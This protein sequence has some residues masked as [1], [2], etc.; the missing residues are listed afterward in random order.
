LLI[1][2]RKSHIRVHTRA[3]RQNICFADRPPLVRQATYDDG[4]NA[5]LWTPKLFNGNPEAGDH[6]KVDEP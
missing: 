5:K 2:L 4:P 3:L 1:R 6:T